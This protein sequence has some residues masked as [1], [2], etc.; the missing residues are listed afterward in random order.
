[1][2][3][4]EYLIKLKE[5][6][7]YGKRTPKPGQYYDQNKVLSISPEDVKKYGYTFIK[8]KQGQLILVDKNY[9][10]IMR[11]VANQPNLEDWIDSNNLWNKPNG[12][13][14]SRK[15]LGIQNPEEINRV[16]NEFQKAGDQTGLAAAT[17]MTSP[18]ILGG[19]I[20]TLPWFTNTVIRPTIQTASALFNPSTKLGAL[21]LSTIMTHDIYKTSR[22]PTAENIAT[23]IL[24]SS[25][26]IGK[27]ASITGVTQGLNKLYN[28]GKNFIKLNSLLNKYD[29]VL[30]SGFNFRTVSPEMA[31]RLADRIMTGTREEDIIQ[32]LLNSKE[33]R[34]TIASYPGLKETLL[35]RYPNYRGQILKINQSKLY[36][37]STPIDAIQEQSIVPKGYKF[38]PRTPKEEFE[39]HF[40]PEEIKPQFNNSSTFKSNLNEQPISNTQKIKDQEIPKNYQENTS[41]VNLDASKEDIANVKSEEKLVNNIEPEK[42]DQDLGT[43][44]DHTPKLRYRL[45]NGD[46]VEVS[47]VNKDGDIYGI[48]LFDN[49]IRLNPEGTEIAAGPQLGI[50]DGSRYNLQPESWKVTSSGNGNYS[51]ES[52]NKK[53]TKFYQYAYTRPIKNENVVTKGLLQKGKETLMGTKTS[54]DNAH[55]SLQN[56]YVSYDPRENTMSIKETGM[57]AAPMRYVS[58]ARILGTVAGLGLAGGKHIY[59]YALKPIYEGLRNY[60][61]YSGTYSP[62]ESKGYNWNGRITLD[63]GVD[64]DTIMRNGTIY[65]ILNEPSTIKDSEYVPSKGGNWYPAS[66]VFKDSEGNYRADP[67]SL[68]HVNKGPF[69]FNLPN[70]TNNQELQ[71]SKPQERNIISPEQQ[72]IDN[73]YNASETESESQQTQQKPKTPNTKHKKKTNKSSLP[74]ITDPD[75]EEYERGEILS[76]IPKQF[77]NTYYG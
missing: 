76:Y 22:N 77:R 53:P 31:N 2:N 13:M 26:A 66:R 70:E 62:N 56:T 49:K 14:D 64:V 21:G 17:L 39:S 5:V 54:Q 8:N 32:I 24:D 16:E 27:L 36:G 28:T 11:D 35:E 75:Y 73:Q 43:G 30:S 68:I 52:L 65:G 58:K 48:D 33:G 10:V 74:K 55:T 42:L 37:T 67:N 44:Q 59:N 7:I 1:M 34:K 71:S 20:K 46:P 51:I 23:L 38:T 61:D 3:K 15:L 4:E 9:N 50:K 57:K 45:P 19:A 72:A 63:N 29:P 47:I 12:L 40:K 60:Y 41:K 69:G 6:P 25:P 18:A